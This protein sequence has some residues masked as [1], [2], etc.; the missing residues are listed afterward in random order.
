MNKLWWK[1][2]F[3]PLTAE[4]MFKPRA[5]ALTKKEVHKVLSEIP[6]TTKLNI[7]DL[8]CGEG[9]HSV[10]FAKKHQVTGLD[11]SK[12]F[13][14]VAKTKIKNSK[15]LKFIFG[16]M[17]HTSKYFKK[18]RFDLVVSMYNSYGYFDK[19][20]DDLKVLTEVHKVLKTGGYFVINTLNGSG[21]KSH[22]GDHKATGIGREVEKNLFVLDNAYFD[23]KTSRTFSDWKIIDARKSKTE[24]FRGHFI[25]NV[26][27][28]KDLKKNLQKSGFKI[29]KTWGALHGTDFDEKTSWHQTVLAQKI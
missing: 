23:Q 20:S 6:I 27:T 1:T 8:C 29:I 28:N 25:Q 22:L 15:N 26:Y 3:K 17:L 9:R 18:E 4:V 7:L 5:G 10:N 11:Y 16:N 14:K 24:I 19:R 13:L 12:N 2:F 21:V